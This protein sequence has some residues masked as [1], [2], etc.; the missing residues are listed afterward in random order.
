MDITCNIEELQEKYRPGRVSNR[1][2][3]GGGGG[4]GAVLKHVVLDPDPRP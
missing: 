2:S 3:G 4:G 1:L